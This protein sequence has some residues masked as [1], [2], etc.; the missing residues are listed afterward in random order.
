MLDALIGS[1]VTLLITIVAIIFGAGK[2][3]G[4]LKTLNDKVSRIDV[5]CR[6][7]NDDDKENASMHTEYR[8]RLTGIDSR[9]KG[10]DNDIKDLRQS[11]E[12]R[13]HW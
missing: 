1:G 13:T 4:E 10:H 7:H 5:N 3:Y 9:L 12:P 6:K 11:V 2:M 8:V